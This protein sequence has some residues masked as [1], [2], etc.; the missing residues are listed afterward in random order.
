VHTWPWSA[1]SSTSRSAPSQV[2]A[3]LADPER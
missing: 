1:G 2:R 3:D